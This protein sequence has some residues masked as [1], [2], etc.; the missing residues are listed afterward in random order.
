M[1]VLEPTFTGNYLLA[2][3]YRPTPRWQH[4]VRDRGSRRCDVGNSIA[5]VKLKDG[6]CEL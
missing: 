3:G 5:S 2:T 1:S 4:L 6:D